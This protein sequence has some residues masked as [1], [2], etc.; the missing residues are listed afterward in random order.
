MPTKC[1]LYARSKPYLLT[2]G[3]RDPVLSPQAEPTAAH[4]AEAVD[5][6]HRTRRRGGQLRKV[7]NLG[8]ILREDLL[9]R[10]VGSGVRE[11]PTPSGDGRRAHD[12]GEAGGGGGA[13][14]A[15]L[16][17]VELER[18][19]EPVDEDDARLDGDDRG[20]GNELL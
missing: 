1:S 7:R 16:G 10:V 19:V 20:G 9:A 13:V 3:E 11:D 12:V 17:G 5:G 14:G 4:V 15:G 8:K 2:Y 6:G 18:L